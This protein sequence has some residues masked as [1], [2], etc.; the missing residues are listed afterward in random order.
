MSEESYHRRVLGLITIPEQVIE[1]LNARIE[2]GSV[3]SISG[4]R[5]LIKAYQTLFSRI[6]ANIFSDENVFC[7]F[8]NRKYKKGRTLFVRPYRY[9]VKNFKLPHILTIRDVQALLPF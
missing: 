8:T 7:H 1:S 6:I 5:H 9:Q 4:V 3:A 2:S